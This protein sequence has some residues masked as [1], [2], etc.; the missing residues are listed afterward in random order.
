MAGAGV[1]FVLALAVGFDQELTQLGRKH[2]ESAAPVFWTAFG[3]WSALPL[4]AALLF[5]LSP[6]R[7]HDRLS[8]T[9]AMN[10]QESDLSG[11]WGTSKR[12][13]W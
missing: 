8:K 6:D 9:G 13:D 2:P 10:R 4:A 12:A 3:W 7:E 5:F 1:G 11:D